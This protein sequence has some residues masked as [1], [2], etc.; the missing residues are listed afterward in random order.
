MPN[1]KENL[2]DNL[3]STFRFSCHRKEL[4][5]KKYWQSSHDAWFPLFHYILFRNSGT[6][7]QQRMGRRA[8]VHSVALAVVVRNRALQLGG[9]RWQP[10]L[11]GRCETQRAR[12]SHVQGIPHPVSPPWLQPNVGLVPQVS[13]GRRRVASS[14]KIWVLTG[15]KVVL[16]SES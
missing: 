1:N 12:R 6:R 13:R 15:F 3:A 10:G 5:N 9:K 11:S 8:L 7:T 2:R 4:R 16:R 14:L